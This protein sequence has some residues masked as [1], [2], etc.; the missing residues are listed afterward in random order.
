[1]KNKRCYFADKGRRCSKES[2]NSSL[3]CTEHNDFLAVF[4]NLMLLNSGAESLVECLFVDENKKVSMTSDVSLLGNFNNYLNA[5]TDRGYKKQEIMAAISEIIREKD[6]LD[7]INKALGLDPKWKK[8]EKIVAG[9][10]MLNAEGADVKFDDRIVGKRTGRERQIDVSIRFKQNYY[11]YL[12]IVECKDYDSRVSIEKVEAFRTKIE[13]V[14]AMKGIMVSPKGFQEGAIKTAQAYNIELFTL[15]EVKSD[16]TRTIKADVLNL[17]YPVNIEFDHPVFYDSA[18]IGQEI[19][20]EDIIFYQDQKTP[21]I[22]LNQIVA[23]TI[24]WVVNEELPT[25]C[26]VELP[27][28][29]PLLTQFPGT[30]FYTPIYGISITL[31]N[32]KFAIGR[33]IDLPPKLIKY[34]YSDLIKNN[35]HEILAKDI[36]KVD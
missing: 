25:P 19:G 2:I 33:K 27:F 3:F 32:E 6:L 20:F 9:I 11:D 18:I 7:D 35:V 8:F 14:G 15:T 22:K 36:P 23:D 5:L 21:P 31:E 28:E 24:L 26:L 12:A 29:P 10:H 30:N 34:V 16:W 1:M 4:D 13:D 17:P